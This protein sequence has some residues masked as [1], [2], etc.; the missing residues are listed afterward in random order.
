MARDGSTGIA[1]VARRWG[2]C[3]ELTAPEHQFADDV[4]QGC[5]SRYLGVLI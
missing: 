3:R 1:V 4:C 5:S 2:Y